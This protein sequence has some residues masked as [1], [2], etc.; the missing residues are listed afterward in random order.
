[1]EWLKSIVRPFV[2]VLLAVAVVYFTGTKIIAADAFLVI[3]T[4]AIVWWYKDRSENK[5]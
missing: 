5:K 1:M 2:T 3:A 4:A